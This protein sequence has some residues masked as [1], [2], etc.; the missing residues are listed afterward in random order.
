[1]SS[2]PEAERERRIIADS[3]RKL[4]W[5]WM[6]FLMLA[7]GMGLYAAT[8]GEIGR[9]ATEQGVWVA[10]L[11]VL[12]L[13]THHWYWNHPDAEWPRDD[14]AIAIALSIQIGLLLPLLTR[15]VWFGGGLIALLGQVSASMTPRRWWIPMAA[16]VLLLLAQL[17]VIDL[18]IAGAW[19]DIG[20]IVLA[21]GWLVLVLLY[22]H[23]TIDERGIRAHLLADIRV[24][25]D[26]IRGVRAPDG[27]IA[28]LRRRLR[29][30]EALSDQQ[31]VTLDAVARA[32]NR[33]GIAAADDRAGLLSALAEAQV[34]LAGAPGMRPGRNSPTAEVAGLPRRAA[35][36]AQ[37]RD[38]AAPA[39]GQPPA[40]P[41]ST[42]P[43]PPPA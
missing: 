19:R 34:L 42:G 29:E 15:N 36:A 28:R 10:A 9:L 11:I 18:V 21:V 20:V 33:A 40:E 2:M 7:F 43:V 35:T 5:F 14:R 17:G 22:T 30:C 3:Q 32:V 41:G 6:V 1:M 24:L 31:A 38:D 39:D 13:I 8:E 23:L 12:F 16:P 25:R 26:E 27:E 4:S 37:R